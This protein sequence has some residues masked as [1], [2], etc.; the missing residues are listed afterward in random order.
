VGSTPCLL[1][2]ILCVVFEARVI[3]LCDR[4]IATL[5]GPDLKTVAQSIN[6]IVFHFR[7]PYSLYK[8][9]KKIGKTVDQTTRWLISMTAI[10]TFP[11]RSHHWHVIEMRKKPPPK[12]PAM[13]GLQESEN[14]S[15]TKSQQTLSFSYKGRGM[16]EVY[17]WIPINIQ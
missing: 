7:S 1:Y 4:D 17:H 14:L 10:T 16:L 6:D 3:N 5:G 8:K 13:V 15:N 2:T 12:T 9:E 11:D